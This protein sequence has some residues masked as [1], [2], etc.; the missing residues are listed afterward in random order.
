MSVV[1]PPLAT[2]TATIAS[3][4]RDHAGSSP[5]LVALR[6]K[7][8]GIWRDVTWHE[9]WERSQEVANGLMALGVEPGDRV[10]IHSENRPEWVYCDT[11]IVSRMSIPEQN[12]RSPAPVSTAQRI[13][14]SLAISRQPSA[15]AQSMLGS[16]ALAR[17]GRS[18]VTRA[19]CGWASGRSSRI[20]MS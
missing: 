10:A 13:A 19:T 9:Y 2:G 14:S 4:L 3:R 1:S 8:L 17:S 11:G 16:R 18:I 15:S 20:G 7:D 6:E 12:T 5:G